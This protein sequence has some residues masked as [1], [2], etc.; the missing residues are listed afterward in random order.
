MY[1]PI[2]CSTPSG[3]SP[4]RQPFNC[5]LGCVAWRCWYSNF[6]TAPTSPP[7]WVS[8]FIGRQLPW[9]PLAMLH[10]FHIL[11]LC[12]MHAL[13]RRGCSNFLAALCCSSDRE[14]IIVGAAMKT[15][16]L[17]A[18]GS[19]TFQWLFAFCYLRYTILYYMLRFHSLWLCVDN[20]YIRPVKECPLRVFAFASF[21]AHCVFESTARDKVISARVHWAIGAKSQ[22]SH[23]WLTVKYITLNGLK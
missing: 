7:H 21:L 13:F 23:V 17:N 22:A 20:N 3:R 12:R 1:A 18:G 4:R 15:R 9:W 14:L 5:F 10:A 8:N 2:Y 6:N 16:N 19:W 11:R